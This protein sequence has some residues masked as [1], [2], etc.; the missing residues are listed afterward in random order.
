LGHAA[1]SQQQG[2]YRLGTINDALLH[3]LINARVVDL[4]VPATKA[5]TAEEFHQQF[6]AALAKKGP[7]LIECQVAYPKAWPTFVENIHRSR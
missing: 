4:G 6:G 1:G 3:E 2:K 7:Q 5:R